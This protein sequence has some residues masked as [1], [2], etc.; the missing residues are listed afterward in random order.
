MIKYIYFLLFL[1]FCTSCSKDA[2]SVEKK[3]VSE[4]LGDILWNTLS[5]ES[6]EYDL[7]T[8][9][10]TIRKNSQGKKKVSENPRIQL[11]KYIEKANET[12]ALI[13]LKQAEDFIAYISSQKESKTLLPGKLL[14]RVLK[15]GTGPIITENSS[16]LLHF[17]EKDLDGEVLYNTYQTNV[18]LRLPLKETILGFKLGI[19]GMQVG[20]RREVI[21][22]PDL[23]YKK[24]GKTKPN[25]LLIYDVTIEGE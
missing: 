4:L 24:L 2:C 3:E 15:Q 5:K 25:Q 22:H 9:L 7:E 6:I 1:S 18:P 23:A 17:I 11:S 20:E 10:D 13:A 21:V 16:P 14:Y 8:V 12:K 19:E